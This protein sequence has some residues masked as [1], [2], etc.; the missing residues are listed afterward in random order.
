MREDYK[1]R[2]PTF[3]KHINGLKWVVRGNKSTKYANRS[4]VEREICR[5]DYIFVICIQK[6]VRITWEIVAFLIPIGIR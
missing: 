5:F 1:A 4:I 6:V 3:K 2:N